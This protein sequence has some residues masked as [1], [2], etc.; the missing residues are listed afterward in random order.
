M[1]RIRTIKP[2][3]PQSETI[4]ALSRDAR[5]LFI[6][7]WTIVDDAGRVRAASR[8]LASL[9]YPYDDDAPKLIDG[10]LDELERHDCVRRYQV[11]GASYL[12]IPNWLKHQKIDKPSA[13][14]IPEFAAH[15]PKP[16]ECSR[17]LVTDLGPRTKDLG[18]DL[19]KEGDVSPPAA[20]PPA[21]PNDTDAAVEAFN[22]VA[23]QAGWP[24]IQRMT[25]GRLT[26]LRAR[27]RDSGGLEGWRAGLA[28]ARASPF[29][30]GQNDRGWKADFDF[31]TRAK[32][33]T[34]LMEGSYD[35]TNDS[36]GKPGPHDAFFAALAE[37]SQAGNGAR[38]RDADADGGVFADDAGSEKNP[39]ND[40]ELSSADYRRTE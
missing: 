17:K 2:E 26:A 31:L 4:G 19:D 6:Q 29:L 25:P 3:F 38:G 33:F 36:H 8:M 10:W 24:R 9:L 20:A 13:S 28:K 34:K 27:L 14:K 39:A 23:E 35:R 12:D 37:Q 1:A 5:L 11:D 40:I 22:A 21:M 15:S 16:R 7:L 32:V 30:C 18:K